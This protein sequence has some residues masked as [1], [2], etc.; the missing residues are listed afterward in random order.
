MTSVILPTHN[1]HAG[2]LARTLD[3]L[4]GQSLPLDRWEVVIVDNASTEPLSDELVNWH[5][6]GRVVRE[7]RLGLT[8]A[9]LAGVAA[10]TGK[11]IVFVDD[12]N[13]LASDYLEHVGKLFDGH[14]QL[15]AA[16]G[17][18][19]PEWEQSPAEWL[20]EFEGNLALRDFGSQPR[21]ERP[22]N[23]Y[24]THAPVGAGMVI[25][26]SAWDAYQGMPGDASVTDRKGNELTSGGDNDIVLSVVRA[27]WEVG[28]FPELM[29]THLIPAGR[30]TAEYL[31]RLNRGIARSWVRV[32]HRHGIRPWPPVSRWTV[33]LRKW[34]AYLSCRAWAGPAEYI[35]WQGA[36]GQFEGR[37]DIAG[38]AR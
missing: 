21:V 8:A 1:P 22:V 27:G 5:P 17:K 13:V 15:G 19:V 20:R 7:N 16:G 37:A 31:A 9:R 24:P 18:C 4:R 29:L 35:R 25:R 3:G 32:L 10:T 14:A 26:R 36:C 11:V 33:P 12:D 30:T 2:R 34:R 28:Y 6:K 38:G 23:A